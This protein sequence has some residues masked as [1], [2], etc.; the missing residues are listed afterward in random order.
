MSDDT[1]PET[2]TICL[3][4]RPP[5]R[6]RKDAWPAIATARYS[7]H[8]GQIECQANRTRRAHI[9]VRRHADGR[10]VVYGSW[11]YD[12][13]WQGESGVTIRHGVFVYRGGDVLAAIRRV[14]AALSGDG[15]DP[16]VVRDLVRECIQALPAE[17]LDAGE[18]RS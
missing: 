4:D 8:D 17:E 12:T 16:A 6:I 15:A 3:T 18:V 11:I 2:I 1:K 14:G 7:W 9:T 10:A 5:V 13:H